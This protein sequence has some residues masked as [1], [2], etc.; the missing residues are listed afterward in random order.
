MTGYA[1]A[2]A[3]TAA[4]YHRE[5]TGEG[6]RIDASLLLTALAL[7]TNFKEVVALDTEPREDWLRALGDARA[8]GATIEETVDEKRRLTPALAGNVYYRT[9]QT[10][11]GY[12]AVGCLGPAPRARFRKAVGVHDPRYDDDFDGSPENT[13]AAGEKLTAEC[14]AIFRTRTTEDWL[15][16]LDANDIACGPVRFVEELWEDSQVQANGF[17][18]EYEHTALGPMRAARPVVSMSATPTRVQR[19]S[20]ALGEHNDEVLAELGFSDADI[21]SL[22]DGGTIR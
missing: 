22:R 17:I 21:A 6:Q 20:P 10:A 3:V 18:A 13:V 16:H 9:Y 4:L 11:D 1:L 7:Q 19:A 15:A 12:L 2:W 14:E 5:R 8:R